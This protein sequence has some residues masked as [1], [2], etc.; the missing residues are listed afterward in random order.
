MWSV[1]LRVA[2]GIDDDV[3]IN[4]NVVDFMDDGMIADATI[5]SH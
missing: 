3:A 1:W 4:G 5:V 2:A